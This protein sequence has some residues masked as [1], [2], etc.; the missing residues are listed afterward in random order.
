LETG[1]ALALDYLNGTIDVAVKNAGRSTIE[2][3]IKTD[4]APVRYARI[5]DSMA[6]DFCKML[7][8]RGF[9]YRDK[10]SAGAFSEWHH[11][12]NCQIVPAFDVALQENK[13]FVWRERGGRGWTQ[14]NVSVRGTD[15]GKVID[16]P[17][18]LDKVIA[19][20]EKELKEG[21]ISQEHFDAHVKAAREAYQ[22]YDPDDS[23]L[24]EAY[25]SWSES[26]KPAQKKRAKGFTKN[27]ATV[28]TQNALTEEYTAL[29]EQADNTQDLNAVWRRVCE[30]TNRNN[31]TMG[32]YKALAEKY[33]ENPYGFKVIK[34]GL[35]S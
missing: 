28:A 23:K 33:Y 31:I 17:D 24:W 13:K 5:A 7:A 34:G 16:S 26:Y 32:Q 4:T 30:S 11:H 9:V 14:N 18:A 1:A 2:E 21:K 27:Q 3:N 15:V 29:I 25:Q 22:N 35:N 8:S 10:N 19:R 12:C 20:Y 6:C